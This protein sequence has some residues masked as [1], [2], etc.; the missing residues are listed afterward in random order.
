M[1][2]TLILRAVCWAPF[3]S[4]FTQSRVE[5][6]E[7]VWENPFFAQLH[8]A[9]V[10]VRS[11][12]VTC[13][14]GIVGKLCAVGKHEIYQAKISSRFWIFERCSDAMN[15]KIR[16]RLLI[17]LLV[18]VCLLSSEHINICLMN[19]NIRQ[20]SKRNFSFRAKF[21]AVERKYC[22][23]QISGFFRLCRLGLM[24]IA[25]KGLR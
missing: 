1:R 24:L 5:S 11:R 21:L 13:H 10:T 12:G 22:F 17:T 3:M 23:P 15:L 14:Y 2:I 18:K 8:V 16:L 6:F 25:R 20:I 7:W 9:I 19:K 4:K